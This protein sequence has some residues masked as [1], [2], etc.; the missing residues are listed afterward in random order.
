MTQ[1]QREMEEQKK[2]LRKIVKPGET[3]YT[4]LCHVSKS[5]MYRVID[6]YVMKKNQPRRISWSTAIVTDMGYDRKHE[7]VKASGCGMDMGFSVVYNL[8]HALYGH[9][10]KCRGK[11]KCPSNY[12]TNH[13]NQVRCKNWCFPDREERKRFYD[14]ENGRQECT[15]CEGGYIPNPDGPERFDLV[16]KD[17]YALNHRWL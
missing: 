1:K 6:T 17:G 14:V 15:A 7:G 11:G 3:V 8:S 13:H 2:E 4:K 10:Y 9:G 16:H 12:H 5:G